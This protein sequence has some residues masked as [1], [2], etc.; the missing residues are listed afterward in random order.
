MGIWAWENTL[1]ESR[2]VYAKIATRGLC[3]TLFLRENLGMESNA[4]IDSLSE[5]S[6]A[7]R[8]IGLIAKSW[9]CV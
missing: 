2:I 8:Y 9:S 3:R 1:L 7:T 4:C 5:L 6:F